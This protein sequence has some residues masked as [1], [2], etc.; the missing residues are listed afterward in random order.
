[1]DTKLTVGL[2][3]RPL[4]LGRGDVPQRGVPADAVVKHFD[5]LEQAG[6]RRLDRR[7]ILVVNQLLLER[8]INY[9]QCV[10]VLSS[11][12]RASTSLVPSASRAVFDGHRVGARTLAIDAI[13]ALQ[14]QMPTRSTGPSRRVT[15][16]NAPNPTTANDER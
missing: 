4:V 9:L 14:P 5:V 8:A 16:A 2:V 3:V 12:L 11:R 13:A 7:V 15:A 6:F 10:N 1:M